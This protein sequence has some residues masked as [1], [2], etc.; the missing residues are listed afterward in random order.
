MFYS[1]FI[2]IM[3]P[4]IAYVLSGRI[5]HGYGYG[6]G[7]G[8]GH[9]TDKVNIS[10]ELTFVDCVDSTADPY[11]IINFWTLGAKMLKCKDSIPK[12]WKWDV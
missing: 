4:S 8:H 9:N 12:I 3:I 11:Y 7:C 1:P 5:G 6:C 10:C 2:S